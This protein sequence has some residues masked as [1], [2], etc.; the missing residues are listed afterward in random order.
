MMSQ[1]CRVRDA[2]FLARFMQSRRPEHQAMWGIRMTIFRRLGLGATLLAT[3]GMQALAADLGEP[4]PKTL[5]PAATATSTPIDF[6]FGAR[7]QSDYNF[8][9][10]SQSNRRPSPQGYFEAQAFDN[11]LYAGIAAYKVDLPTRPGAEIDLTAGIRP[12]LGPLQF[13]FGVIY[14]FYPNERRLVDQLGTYYSVANTDFLELAGKVSYT[15]QEALTVGAN[16]FHAWD[17]LGSGA[18]ATYVSG[19]VKYT[20]PEG[21]LPA[22]FAV[23]GELGRY[24]LGTTSPQLGSVRLPDYTYWNAG[25]SYTYKN[26]TLD[27]RYHDTNLSKRECFT[28]SGD[29][30]GIF[31]GSGRSNWCGEA[32]I[33]TLAVDF[34]ASQLPGIFK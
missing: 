20:I 30:K 21:P 11:L 17:W 29:P 19:T 7:V 26:L 3:L 4:P 18:R 16:V 2:A 32:F 10:I 8:R 25:L 28:V 6:V 34:T 1:P 23:S 27:L 24:F 13:D 33:A 14:Y 9:G 12:K 31:T 5:P 22:G 15:Y